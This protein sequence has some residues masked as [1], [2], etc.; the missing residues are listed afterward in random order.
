MKIAFDLRRI[1]N[2]GIGR[3]MKCLVEAVLARAPEHEYLLILPPDAKEVIT[4]QD[5]RVEK[6]LSPSTYYSLQEQV[7]LPR[8]LRRHKAD[9]LH[10]PHFNIPLMRPCPTVVTIHDVIYLA[11][12]QD[13]PSRLGRLYYHVMMAAAVR[14]ADR[15]L[16]VSEFSRNEILRYLNADP[17]K[18]AVVYSG[19]DPAFQRVCDAAQIEAVLSKYRIDEDYI[20]YTGICKPRKNHAGLL[21]AFREFLKSG[22]SAKLVIAGPIGNREA[23]ADLRRFGNELGIAGKLIFTGFVPES[24]LA[25]LYSAARVYACPSLYEGFGFTVLEAMTC[26]V[27]VVCSRNTSLAEVAGDAALHADSQNPHEFAAALRRAF[28]EEELRRQLI[29]KGHSN[30]RRFSWQ[31]AA[32][33]TLAAYERVAGYPV[34]KAVFA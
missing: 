34:E 18:I 6:V 3:Y 1:K 26:G 33:A 23:E 13:M 24:D 21:R 19:V 12:K 16:T 27:P 25:S 14:L 8:L 5:R 17:A 28:S 2:P 22:E 10:A 4:F 30:C 9:L 20:L 29:E 11:C 32:S 15:V 31:R 7:E